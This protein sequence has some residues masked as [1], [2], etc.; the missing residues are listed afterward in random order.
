M[1]FTILH[2][3]VL[4]FLFLFL[5]TGNSF[6]TVYYISA[7]GNDSNNGTSPGTSWQSLSKVNSVMPS[8]VAGDQFL[9]NKGDTFY[10]QVTITKTGSLGNEIIFGSYGSG[11]PPIFSGKKI[12]TGWTQHS[13][14]IYKA[15]FSDS[16]NHIYVNGKLMTIARYPNTGFLKID[17]PNG[18]TGLYSTQL[19]QPSGFWNGANCRIRTITWAYETK[20]VASF[21]GGTVTFTTP[22]TYATALNYG[23]YMDNKLNLLD[24]QNE[25]FQDFS[26][27]YVYIYAPGGINPN[28]IQVEGTVAK[29]GI[30]V[31]Q[32]RNFI[33]IQNLNFNG[34]ANAGVNVPTS[35]N[36][37]VTGC[38]VTQISNYGIIINGN[39]AIINN[40]FI[41]DILNSAI[42][43]IINK[44][45][46]KN[47]NINRTG[48]VPGYGV[49]IRGYLGLEILFSKGL[50]VE[51]NIIDSTGYSAIS[52]GLSSIVRNNYINYSM[53]TLNDGAG[54]DIGDSDTLQ[55]IDNV[56]LNTIGSTESCA[57]SDSYCSGI[58]VNAGVLKNSLIKGNTCANNTYAGIYID[59]KTGT[60]N[61]QIIGN[62]LYNNNKIQMLFADYSIG[63]NTPVFNTIVKKNILYSL[64]SEQNCLVLR[65][66]SGS[67]QNDYGDFDSNYYCNPY[68]DYTI[69]R[70]KFTAPYSDLV[71]SLSEWQNIS[72]EDLHS[73]SS[74][75]HFSQFGITD[76]LSSNMITN[77]HFNSN[78]S[79]WVGWP[80]GV[81]MGW[82]THPM[83]DSGCLKMRWN[84]NGNGLGLSLT[85][86]YS[87]SSGS[88]YLVSISASGD[89]NGT[90]NMWGLSSLSGSTFTFPQKF[91]NF[92]NTRRN[93]SFTYKAEINDPQAYM[94]V[95]LILP[96][97]VVYF[98]NVNMYK[99][100]VEKIDSTQLS[101]LFVNH[102][103][104]AQSFSL[105]GIA[106]KDLDGN[107]ITGS[108]QLQPYSSQILVNEEYIPSRK[109]NLKAFIEGFYNPSTGKMKSDTATVY[110]RNSSSPYSIVDSA[111]SV[112][113]SNGNGT[114]NFYN[115]YN[116]VNYLISV[117][118]RNSLETWSSTYVSFVNNILNYDFTTAASKAYG[119]NLVSVGGKYCI[120]S[121]EVIYDGQ[122]ELSDILMISNAAN[123]FLTGYVVE[124][125]NGDNI[126]DLS[127]V[128]IAYNNSSAFV[129]AIIP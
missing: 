40:N 36:V 127:D 59:H 44:G 85:N 103:N 111:S 64:Q 8:A 37:S 82:S 84:G 115:P 93:Y 126:T 16:I 15:A 56:I 63:I 14:S 122:I 94:S 34:Y 28:T 67:S 45:E 48:L 110:I 106:Y 108:I 52:V 124:D 13:G 102:N 18:N 101:K 97:S 95:G 104:T 88:H 43:G 30:H 2:K 91:F 7:S 70:T 3:F 5:F 61:N 68:S 65:T 9:F 89:H 10:G 105:N 41:E 39:N 23:F 125:V 51:N 78:I 90:F 96:D 62:T 50:L 60:E 71:H 80:S 21:G 120:Y 38:S 22:T 49:N 113:D 112:L 24:I 98:D 76:T 83:L 72:N 19:N 27:G 116:S 26:S 53:L 92:D 100:N 35:N 69:R 6:S 66:Y 17:Y 107:P 12:I 54:I 55:V 74:I 119:N 11:N 128:G 99:V 75:F 33:K 1:S 47:N 25:W 31:N 129:N 87:I 4:S 20:K 109:L 86:R 123:I 117:K 42:F 81:T 79:N 57:T 32:N 29:N 114:F 46:I 58:Y 121:G 73:K 118:H 77:S